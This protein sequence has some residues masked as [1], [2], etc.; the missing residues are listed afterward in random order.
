MAERVDTAINRIPMIENPLPLL[1][2]FQL[3]SPSLPTGA[4]SYSQ[5]LEWAREISWIQNGDDVA[6]W[7]N[8]ILYTS[9]AEMELPLLIRLYQASG[10]EDE[11]AFVHWQQTTLACRET[12]ELRGEEKVRGRALVKLL[13]E[14]GVKSKLLP[15][16]ANSQLAGFALASS[17]W[18]IS[19]EECCYGYLWSWLEN[20][21]MAAIKIV[22]LGQ[23]DGQKL[24]QQ[25]F[26]K[27]PEIISLADKIK[28]D[29]I[30]GSCPAV[31]FAS[32]KHEQQYTRLFR[33]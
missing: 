23:T 8:S 16:C 1:R 19:R 5:G 12:N 3:I 25:I 20:M 21:I 9:F 29:E 15:H 24:L 2:L 22:P 31:V 26:I 28:D 6:T 4:F 18:N 7:L 17:F 30:A 14:L 13:G 11:K 33:S 32:C 10:S 27:F